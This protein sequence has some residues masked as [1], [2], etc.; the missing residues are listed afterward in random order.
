LAHRATACSYPK[1]LRPHRHVT[2]AAQALSRFIG[3]REAFE[4]T[5]IEGGQKAQPLDVVRVPVATLPSVDPRAAVQWHRLID[6]LPADSLARRE[7][8]IAH[9]SV[10]SISRGVTFANWVLGES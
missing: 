6:E 8:A 5:G 9:S 2:R 7:M 1:T 3:G 10:L 4:L